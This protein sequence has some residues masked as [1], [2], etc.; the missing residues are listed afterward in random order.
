M[1]S[2]SNFGVRAEASRLD[3]F[4]TTMR[5]GRGWAGGFSVRASRVEDCFPSSFIRV[6]AR[7]LVSRRARRRGVLFCFACQGAKEPFCR[8]ADVAGVASEGRALHRPLLPGGDGL[9]PHR[10]DGAYPRDED[11]RL[12]AG[13]DVFSGTNS[14]TSLFYCCCLLRRGRRKE[15]KDAIYLKFR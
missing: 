1:F 9:P 6:Q 7:P 4:H 2:A 8:S 13:T 15:S 12:S 5:S 11:L 3:A 10:L 14:R